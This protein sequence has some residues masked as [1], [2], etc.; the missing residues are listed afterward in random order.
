MIEAVCYFI[1]KR[2][3]LIL[4]VSLLLIGCS[5]EPD[6]SLKIRNRDNQTLRSINIGG[7]NFK[8]LEPG[9]ASEYMPIPEGSHTVSWIRNSI[10]GQ[11]T[12]PI[13]IEGKGTHK[14]TLILSYYRWELVKD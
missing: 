13:V 8:N 7:V 9:E 12:E 14:W 11:T 3:V 2:S 10:T 1:S 5:K 4:F 6:H